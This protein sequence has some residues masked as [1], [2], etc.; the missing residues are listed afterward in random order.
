MQIQIFSEIGYGN[1]SF[2]STE[3]EKGKYEH[4]IRGFVIPKNIEGIYLRIWIWKKVF[5]ISSKNGFSLN[6]KDRVKIKFLFGFE[7]SRD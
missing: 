1:D 6:S 2:C 3:I 7:G 5:V 4:R